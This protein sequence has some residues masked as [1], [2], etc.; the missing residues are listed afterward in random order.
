MKPSKG[1]YGE[2]GKDV[3]ALENETTGDYCSYVIKSGNLKEHLDGKYGILKQMKDALFIDL[4]Y[5]ECK[6]KKR[7]VTVVHNGDE[8]NRSAINTFE[9]KRV[10]FENVIDESIL[11]RPIERWD[12]DILCDKLFPNWEILEKNEDV[13]LYYESLQRIKSITLES[14]EKYHLLI[15]TGQIS[16][17]ECKDILSEHFKVIGSITKNYSFNK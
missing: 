8:G 6:S 12:I 2:Q 7:T 15:E 11:L 4:E 17:E 5:E 16:N 9:V 10:E 1:R 14:Y 3:V 13:R